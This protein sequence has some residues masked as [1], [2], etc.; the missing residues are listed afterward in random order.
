MEFSIVFFPNFK[1]NL[2]NI[3]TIS[4]KPIRKLRLFF[5]KFVLTSQ[6]RRSSILNSV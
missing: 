6:M 2:E 4:I 5:W 3:D 1:E